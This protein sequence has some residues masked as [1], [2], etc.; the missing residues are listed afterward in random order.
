M[1]VRPAF[2]SPYGNHGLRRRVIGRAP[3]LGPNA[4]GRTGSA[5]ARVGHDVL[6][7]EETGQARSDDSLI[8]RLA[9]Q[10]QRTLVTIDRHFGDW[11]VLPLSEHYGVIRVGAHPTSMANV[12]QLL[13]PLLTNHSQ[14]EFRNKLVIISPRRVRWVQTNKSEK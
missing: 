8:L 10:E 9:V 4:S 2:H 12:A 7:A 1:V 14:E 11:V 5:F 6:R 3:L 13:I